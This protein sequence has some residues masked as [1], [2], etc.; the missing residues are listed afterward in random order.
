MGRIRY[1]YSII[2]FLWVFLDIL[3]LAFPALFFFRVVVRNRFF[4]LSR[5]IIELSVPLYLT[6]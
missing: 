4:F 5:D 1:H 6:L 3:Q 2:F